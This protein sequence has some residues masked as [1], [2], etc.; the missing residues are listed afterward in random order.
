[1]LTCLSLLSDALG[2]KLG[3]RRVSDHAPFLS[4]A[5]CDAYNHVQKLQRRIA[6]SRGLAAEASLLPSKQPIFEEP[7]LEPPPTVQQPVKIELRD[8]TP[9]AVTKRKYRR[10]P[11]PDENA[12]ERPPSA[13]VLFSNSKRC[14]PGSYVRTPCVSTNMVNQK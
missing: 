5:S 10:H 6:N 8:V 7:K 11:K 1:M 2:V 14:F 9:V 12:P 3:H 4:F 13:Y